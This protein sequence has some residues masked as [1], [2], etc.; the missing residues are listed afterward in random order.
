[1]ECVAQ[2]EGPDA[3]TVGVE[4][5]GWLGAETVQLLRLPARQHAATTPRRFQN[6][7]A[8]VAC[9]PGLLAATTQRA[10]AASF[11][12]LPP[13]EA[14]RDGHVPELHELLAGTSSGNCLVGPSHADDI[15]QMQ[16]GHG[17]IRLGG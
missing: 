8:W 14:P 11:L 13:A 7:T 4:V 2:D 5:G 17:K 10:Y 9:W 12:E 15:R 1:M 16:K 6:S 3:A